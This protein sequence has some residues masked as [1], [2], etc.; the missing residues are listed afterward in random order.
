MEELKTRCPRCGRPAT[1]IIRGYPDPE[2]LEELKRAG[3]DYELAGCLVS[4]GNPD[5]KSDTCGLKWR[6]GA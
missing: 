5:R 1:V 4:E 2:A 6:E 3:V